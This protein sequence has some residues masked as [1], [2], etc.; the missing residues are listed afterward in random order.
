MQV[1]SDDAQVSID[2]M[3]AAAGFTDLSPDAGVVIQDV[4]GEIVAACAQ[5]ETILG[6][7][8]DQ[9]RGRTSQDPRWAA[10]DES[11]QFVEGAQH[12]AIIALRTRTAIRGQIIGAHRPGSDAAGHHVWL[13]VD[14][15]P[16]FRGGDPEPW[17]VVV[18]FRPVRGER[19]RALELRDSERLFRMIAEH[20]SDMV[21]W[22]LVPDTTFLWVSPAS[23]TVL[24]FHP[25][26]LI[27]TY[28]I[29]L[30]HPDDRARLAE[31]WPAA[32]DALPRFMM[33]MRHAD[34]S[35]RWIETTAHVLPAQEGRPQQMITAHRDVSDRVIA[36]RARDAA[37]GMFEMAMQH[38][39]IGVAWRQR[40][41]VLSR[42]NPALCSILGRSADEL[43]GHSLREFALDEDFGRDDA[44]ADVQAGTRGH[45]ESERRFVRP[46][47]TVAWCL[48]TL[49]GLPDESG[50]I[51]QFLV[52]LQDITEQKNAAA[53]LERAAL[54]D[55]LTGLPNR[56]VLEG[57]LTDAL[58]AARS[59][60]TKVGVLFI[61]L[62]QFKQVN[63][64]LGH[65]AGDDLLRE[66]GI[67]LSAVVR[68]T[69]T[70][71]RLGGDE[72]VIVREHLSG[73]EQLDDLIERVQDVFATPFAINGCQ[74]AVNAS[75][76]S[77][78]G[79]HSTA[80][81][82]L[83]DADEAM[84]RAKRGAGSPPEYHL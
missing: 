61:D 57:R 56:T 45:H 81:Q 26:D 2:S 44:I 34:G 84:Y 71:V 14:A 73:P 50:A 23:R 72:F 62:D 58:T 35:Y 28:G 11:G 19:L 36:E 74:L 16:L 5:A 53:R 31:S 42:V 9:M 67:R 41:G 70:T 25:D 40:D 65:D 15:V 10:V 33:R 21:A 49:I 64:T 39:T 60:N 37:V 38:A 52:Q 51:T 77:A 20:S 12:P 27:G 68:H 7:T 29:D 78:A 32:T 18:V 22:Q 79:D 75:I 30:V 4:D 43:V 13:H 48:H 3:V 8:I 6:L 69:D 66:V 55:P 80:D 54:T 46:D 1:E 76:G 82:L 17:A 24:G 83:S 63:D 47:G 59:D